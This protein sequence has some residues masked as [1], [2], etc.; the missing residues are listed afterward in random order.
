MS[1]VTYLIDGANWCHAAFHADVDIE[2]MIRGFQKRARRPP[3]VFAALEG[4]GET[5]R[6][7]LFPG[8]K[9]G[10]EEKDEE[11]V[12]MLASLP[13]IFSRC[14]IRTVT[15]PSGYEADDVLATMAANASGRVM[16]LTA[17]TDLIQVVSDNVFL[18]RRRGGEALVTRPRDV[19]R[20]Y[21]VWPSQWT[22]Y[23]GLVGKPSNGLAGVPGIGAK[24]AASLIRE[25]G[26]LEEILK[27]PVRMKAEYRAKLKGHEDEARLTQKLSTLK[28]D[29]AIP[30]LIEKISRRV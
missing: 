9:A 26:S 10:R 17:D 6:A 16:I 3:N 7:R 28:R 19:A 27:R 11:L 21:G 1:H 30:I 20:R 24:G 13:G 23:L 12:E 22:D 14:G 8:F 18:G 15:A 5:W 2:A 4:P 29:L 25:F